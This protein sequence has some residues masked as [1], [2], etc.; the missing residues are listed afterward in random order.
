M[1]PC[2]YVHA[3]PMIICPDSDIKLDYYSRKQKYTV[4]TQAVV[5]ADLVF[6]DVATGFADSAHDD[7]H[8][9]SLVLR[10]S[11][12]FAQAERREIYLAHLKNWLTGFLSDL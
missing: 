10:S 11:S 6:Q 2:W 1:E 12:L 5:G 3:E 7:F 8:F 4:K 9:F